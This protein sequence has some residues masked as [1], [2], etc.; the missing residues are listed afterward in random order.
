MRPPRLTPKIGL[1]LG[2]ITDDN[3]F[4]PWVRLWAPNGTVL[5][6]TA[7]VNAAQVNG[8]VAPVTGTYFVLVASYD[9]FLDGT[10]TYQLTMTHTPGPITTSAGDEGGPLVN[11]ATHTGTIN[12]GDL[13]VR[14]L[15]DR[16]DH[17]TA[18]LIEERENTVTAGKR[19]GHGLLDVGRRLHALQY[20]FARRELYADLDFHVLPP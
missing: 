8:V 18:L 7:G 6:D 20:E 10:G 16:R 9:S 1:N 15:V 4:R 17:P 5:A 12:L 14:Q 3:D 11:G 13:D 2:Q 19:L